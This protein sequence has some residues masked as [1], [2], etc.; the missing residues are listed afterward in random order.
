M[1]TAIAKSQPL[2]QVRTA[3]SAIDTQWGRL[4]WRRYLEV[5]RDHLDDGTRY[6]HVSIVSSAGGLS[7][8]ADLLD[9]FRARLAMAGRSTA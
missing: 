8:H 4:T 5:L 3:E 9:V 1:S 2:T 7:L 6:E